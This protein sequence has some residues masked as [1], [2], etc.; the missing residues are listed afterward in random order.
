VRLN[1]DGSPVRGPGALVELEDYEKT[2][3]PALVDRY[4]T[5]G[6]CWVVTGS[7]QYGRAYADPK[8]V[9]RALPYYAHLKATADL[10]Y[11]I[12]PYK[13]GAQGVPFSF[14]YSFNYYPLQYSRPGPEVDVY[15]LRNCT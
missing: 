14:D 8:A 9:P 15:R 3:Q 10:A 1:P 6:Y 7:T 5:L 2:L 13:A 11:K 12:A 4:R